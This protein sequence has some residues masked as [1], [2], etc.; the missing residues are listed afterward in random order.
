[1]SDKRKTEIQDRQE[2]ATSK[3]TLRDIEREKSIDTS[4]GS[5]KLPSPDGA[6][7]DGDELE[8]A[9]PM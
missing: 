4:P 7:D 3:E 8:D 5:S 2:E 6:M 1:M 9:G